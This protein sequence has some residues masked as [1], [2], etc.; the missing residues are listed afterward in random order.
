MNNQINQGLK[1]R[2][3]SNEAEV[4]RYF[5][6]MN[7]LFN[8][9]KAGNYLL[10]GQLNEKKNRFVESRYPNEI[11]VSIDRN[12][13]YLHERGGSHRLS[14]AKILKIKKVPVVV[15]RKHLKIFLKEK[16]HDNFI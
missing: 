9:L 12:G 16:K 3:C 11:I 8:K 14:M 6:Q 15:I 10:Q 7:I 1:P 2:G 13:N 4:F 5:E